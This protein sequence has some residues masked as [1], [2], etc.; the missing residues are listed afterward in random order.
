MMLQITSEWIMLS[1]RKI[2]SKLP[3]QHQAF[4]LQR[5][6]MT[7]SWANS[8]KWQAVRSRLKPANPM[9]KCAISKWYK[10]YHGLLLG[11][12]ITAVA[13]VHHQ[14]P[15][16]DLLRLCVC[17]KIHHTVSEKQM[18]TTHFIWTPGSRRHPDN[19]HGGEPSLGSAP[20]RN[21]LSSCWI[22]QSVCLY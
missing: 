21:G 4:S 2:S 8:V 20:L 10:W 1:K 14:L 6:F 7:R 12:P 18:G 15:D 3:T 19:T 11:A 22:E 17:V 13:G 9:P 16:P 5:K